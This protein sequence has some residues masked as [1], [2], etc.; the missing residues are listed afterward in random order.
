MRREPPG[1]GQSDDRDRAVGPGTGLGRRLI[2]PE[3]YLGDPHPLYARL[4]AEAPVAWN[5]E[6]GF[7]AVRR[8]A[9]VCAV[10][11]DPRP[12]APARASSP[13]RSAS[14]TRRRRR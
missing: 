7:W 1:P 5:E 8:H 12:S 10:E 4:R 2:D 13:T 11:S 6:L 14:T 3:L 9:D